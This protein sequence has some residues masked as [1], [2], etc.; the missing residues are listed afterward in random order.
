MDLFNYVA[1]RKLISD[2]ASGKKPLPVLSEK[3][4]INSSQMKQIEL[5]IEYGLKPSQIM[6]YIDQPAERMEELRLCLLAGMPDAQVKKYANTNYSTYLAW[7]DYPKK[8]FNELGLGPLREIRL[9]FEHGLSIE[10]IKMYDGTYQDSVRDLN[11]RQM[12]QI[13]LGLEHNLSTEQVQL[14]ADKEME[15]FKMEQIRL[16]LEDGFSIE[17]VKK[18]IDLGLDG[19]QMNRVRYGLEH[20]FT[21]EQIEMYAKPDIDVLKMDELIFGIEH[22][23]SSDQLE[24][25]INNPLSPTAMRQIMLGA[26][27]GLSNEQLIFC[28]KNAHSE[29]ELTQMRINLE[30]ELFHKEVEPKVETDFA[31]QSESGQRLSYEQVEPYLHPSAEANEA[32][33]SSFES[34]QGLL[35]YEQIEPYLHP[36]AEANEAAKSCFENDVVFT[37]DDEELEEDYGDSSEP[38]EYAP[39]RND[40]RFADIADNIEDYDIEELEYYK[41]HPEECGEIEEPEEDDLEL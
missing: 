28:I 38:D 30:N 1:N 24:I 19:A 27:H 39:Y 34:V 20:N 6:I 31:S 9:G 35:S 16:I 41:A 13:R 22:G 21:N 2:I 36:S 3:Y 11:Y 32:A 40:P 26:E 17:Q 33:R 25:C 15:L 23:L 8:R 10:Q 18:Y 37:Q 5:G 29:D 12:E 7:V 4:N 14:F